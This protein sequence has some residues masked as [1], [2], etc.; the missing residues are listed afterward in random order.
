MFI[1]GIQNTHTLSGA[2]FSRSLDTSEEIGTPR[3][4]E[5]DTVRREHYLLRF[6][7]LSFHWMLFKVL[8]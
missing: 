5:H 4:I 8:Q 1:V 7:T 3:Q 6:L 2:L